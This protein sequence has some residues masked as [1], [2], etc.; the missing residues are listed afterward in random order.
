MQAALRSVPVCT[1]IVLLLGMLLPQAAMAAPTQSFLQP[2]G[3][4]AEEQAAHLWRVIAIAMVVIL[5]VLIGVP[6]LVWRYRI[7]AKGAKYTPEWDYSAKLEWLLWGVPVAVVIVLASWLW[8]S[9]NRLDP[10]EPMGPQPLR[11]QAIGLDWKWVFLY[12][13]EGVATVNALA[14]P[15]GRPVELTL[16]TDTVMQSMLI[17]PLTGQIYAMPGMTTKLNF[18]ATRTGV[19]EGENTQFNGAG[20]GRQKFTVTAMAPARHAAWLADA[21]RAPMLDAATYRILRHR[22]VLAEARGELGLSRA[23]TPLYFALPIPDMFERVVAKY[24][25]TDGG[26]SGALG[27]TGLPPRPQGGDE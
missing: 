5:P 19:A 24:H 1:G 27:G 17:A 13:D 26:G 25:A 4:V 3:P 15:V 23:A 7:G 22:S 12:P 9:T 10:Y 18:A 11:I 16:T 21:R 2:M 20:F 6:L 8:Y 14:I